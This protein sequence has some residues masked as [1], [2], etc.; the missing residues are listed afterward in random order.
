M[1]TLKVSCRLLNIFSGSTVGADLRD[2]RS[3]G[4]TVGQNHPPASYKYKLTIARIELPGSGY[5]F[6]D[7]ARGNV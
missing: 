5:V 3:V 2:R 1:L 4:R 6:E 7:G